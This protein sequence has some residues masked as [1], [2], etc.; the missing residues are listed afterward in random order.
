MVIEEQFFFNGKL[1]FCHAASRPFQIYFSEVQP[2]CS[3]SIWLL[4]SF[5]T[6]WSLFLFTGLAQDC[7]PK[8]ALLNYHSC[9]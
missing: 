2:I 1:P 8:S 9:S 5:H 4:K 3:S 7:E 6:Y